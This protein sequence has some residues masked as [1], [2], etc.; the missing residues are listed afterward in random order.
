MVTDTFFDLQ[1]FADDTLVGSSVDGGTF[2]WAEVDETTGERV[3][4]FVNSG[5]A[6]S[7]VYQLATTGGVSAVT[8]SMQIALNG[9]KEGYS[10]AI[11][12]EKDNWEVAIKGTKN[13]LSGDFSQ[14]DGSYGLAGEVDVTVLQNKT[15]NEAVN[16][17]TTYVKA[18]AA[19]VAVKVESSSTTAINYTFDNVANVAI[20]V[21]NDDTAVFNGGANNV[22][23]GAAAGEAAVS[24]PG[25]NFGGDATVTSNGSNVNIAVKE[26]VQVEADE[27]RWVFDNKS[28]RDVSNV[29]INSSGDIAL[30]SATKAADLYSDSGVDTSLAVVIGNSIASWDQ[31][32]GNINNTYDENNNA[33]A[34]AIH[35]DKDGA[36][37]NNAGEVTVKGSSGDHAGFATLTA[38]GI[39]ANDVTIQAAEGGLS[40]FAVD[41]SETTGIDGIAVDNEDAAVKIAGD[42]SFNVKVG[43]K[44]TY[45]VATTA[46]D[47][48]FDAGENELVANVVSGKEYSVT[49]GDATYIVNNVVRG[50]NV[51][52]GING[53]AVAINNNGNATDYYPLTSD[54]N[55]AGVDTV[56]LLKPNDAVSVTGDSDGY[57]ATYIEATTARG[58]AATDTVSF[59]VNNAKISVQAGYVDADRVTITSDSAGS[60]VTVQG[61]EGGAVV[62]VASGATYHFKNDRD[63]NIVTVAGS[64]YTEVTLNANGDVASQTDPVYGTV[65]NVINDD[66]KPRVAAD[67]TKWNEKSTVGGASDT[68]VSNHAS[69]Y[70]DFYSLNNS[71]VSGNTLAGY[72]SQNDSAPGSTSSAINI[73]GNTNLG[74]AV[75]ITLTGDSN[76]GQVPINIQSNENSNARDVTIDLTNSNVPSSVAV[77]TTG[78]VTAAHDIRLSNAGTAAAPSYGY[79]GAGATGENKLSV[80]TGTAILRHDGTNRT[81]ISGGTG[82]DT[83][84]GDVNDIV[85]GGT[86]GDVFYDLS[87]YALDYNVAEGDIIIAS[88]LADLSEVTAAN[89]RGNG[90][91]IGFGNGEYLLTLGNI[92]QNSAVHVKVGVMDN[93]GNLLNG[94][95]DVVLA[96][97]NG[98]VD[99]T[100]AGTNGALIV[101]NASRGAGV[102][103][104]VGSEGADDIYV[105]SYDVVSG[106]AGNDYIHIDQGAAGVVVAMSAGA[107]SV[108]G[109]NFGFDTAAGATQLNTN[110]MN[111]VGRMYEDRLLLSLEGGASISFDDT[112]LLGVNNGMHGQYN[113][114]VNDLKYIGIRNGDNSG[115]TPGY[116]YINSNDDI[117]D[118]YFAEREGLL[119]FDSGVTEDLGV[120]DLTSPNYQDIR[121]L[122]LSNNSNAVVYGSTERETVSLGGAASVGATKIISLGGGND[123]IYSGGDTPG[124]ATHVF[125]FGTGDGR[126]SLFSYNH[127]EGL[128]ADPDR[129]NA[130]V[131]IL[132]GLAGLKAEVETETGYTRVEF[133][134][135]NN[136]D[137]GVV[138]EAPGTYDY[139]ADMY[140]VHIIDSGANGVAKIG[141]STIANTFSYDKEV[142]FYVGSSGEARDTLVVGNADKNVEVRM[143][144]QKQDGKFYRGIGVI[145]ASAASYTNTTLAGSA[146]NN[147]IVAGGEGTNNFLWGG[148]GSNTLVGGA[149]K[150][151]FLYT[152]NA[153][154]YVAGADHS[155]TSGT[156]DIVVGYDC[157]NDVIILSDVT[158]ADINY[159]AMNQASGGTGY[160]ITENGVTVALNNGGSVTVDPTGQSKVQF[161]IN[162]GAGNLTGFTA[163]RD[164]GA[165]S[166]G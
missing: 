119:W 9:T 147:M 87:G 19:D 136:G 129:Q 138:Y 166:R 76:I 86:G 29:I 1:R 22:S 114:L 88:R 63:R 73:L 44:A 2:N 143:D 10:F 97:G 35:F 113:V 118:A 162:D 62:S 18:G 109:W 148:A 106:A 71:G 128:S 57:T 120:I 27:K 98:A 99:A 49:G 110:G 149:G 16:G 160:G 38:A 64:Q 130:D 100:A 3:H 137:Y 36:H 83:I 157:N 131:I 32:T 103:A 26:G 141:Y 89:I 164:T 69:V 124:V 104:V 155:D 52:V 70:E 132:Q 72:A 101:S 115:Q 151:F 85:S 84:R 40:T 107:D 37:I 41:L 102:H 75:H 17:S 122:W 142:N 81:S 48:T 92:D 111:V 123:V 34:P 59:E 74:E 94:V 6:E 24:I 14:V 161:F 39:V 5:T 56:G 11:N 163:N 79:L 50:G 146:A 31:I 53:A 21:D 90:N 126:D 8:G 66:S 112:K 33:V 96:N 47:I 82:N 95:R 7:P 145:D 43:A 68:V 58:Y 135:N 156:N 133:A 15:F 51:S 121:N 108:A 80:E 78:N 117:A 165:W 153:N 116:A 20:G 77:G 105:G 55:R 91:Q 30:V 13:T 144:G 61:I 154:A 23:L 139:N 67:Q 127:Y 60:N 28:S 150:D 158:L 54:K 159:A 134:V 42:K 140:R 45:D 46:D 125:Y 152:K 4:S 93:D 12:E 25:V 65:E